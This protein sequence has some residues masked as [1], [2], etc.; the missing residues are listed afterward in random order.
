MTAAMLSHGAPRGSLI[1]RLRDLSRLDEEL[2]SNFRRYV[3]QL[4]EQ[5]QRYYPQLLVLC[6][7]ADEPWLWSLLEAAPDAAKAR[8]WS[9]ARVEK[10]LRAAE[11]VAQLRAPGFALLPGTVEAASEHALLLVPNL[12]L[13]GSTA[14]RA[15]SAH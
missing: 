6:P 5:L 14:C 4:R 1:L 11:V 3:C 8:R 15:G 7:Q 13:A 10:R 2:G 12:R 9:E